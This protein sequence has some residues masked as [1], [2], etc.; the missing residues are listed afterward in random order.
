KRAGD[1]AVGQIFA[2]NVHGA[3]G[4]LRGT[5]RLGW[6]H[7]LRVIIPES[8]FFV[9]VGCLNRENAKA[10]KGAKYLITE[11][12]TPVFRVF[13]CFRFVYFVVFVF[14]RFEPFPLSSAGRR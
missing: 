2:G 5:R 1:L 8:L 12:A 10:A 3:L 6:R 14:S 13:R 11:V 7:V 9:T 4:L